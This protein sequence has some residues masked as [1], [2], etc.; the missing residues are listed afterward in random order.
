MTT[1]LQSEI[2]DTRPP[3]GV[4]RVANPI[5]KALLRTPLS[6][7]LRPLALLEFPGR[8]TGR[9]I[10]VVV[11]WHHVDGNPVVVTPAAWRVNFSDQTPATVTWRGRRRHYLATLYDDPTQVATT[12][13]AILRNGS[14]PRAIALHLP[15]HH[16]ITPHDVLQTRRAIIR[17]QPTDHSLASEGPTGNDLDPAVEKQP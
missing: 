7:L 15:A 13:N 3:T 5:L 4:L 2:R 9:T 12:L 8:R 16:I 1:D 17:F 6:R 11:A 14:S 10:R